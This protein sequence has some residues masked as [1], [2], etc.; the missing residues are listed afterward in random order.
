[1]RFPFNLIMRPLGGIAIDR[2][3]RKD[4]NRPSLVEAMVEL[5]NNNKDLIIVITPEGT[6]SRQTSWKTGFFHVAQ[7]AH[8]PILLGYVDYKT[9]T[10]GIGKKVIPTTYPETMQEIMDFYQNIHPRFPEKFALD[11]SF[12]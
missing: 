4:G 2:S 7:N 12:L 3:P 9:K 11:Q 6:R 1:M 8:V 10:A 5:F